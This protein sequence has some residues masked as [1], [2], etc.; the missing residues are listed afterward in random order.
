MQAVCQGQRPL[1]FRGLPYL[2]DCDVAVHCEDTSIALV[3]LR[4]PREIRR[5]VGPNDDRILAHLEQTSV[6]APSFHSARG[7]APSLGRP[8]HTRAPGTVTA[9]SYH[10]HQPRGYRPPPRRWTGHLRIR[11]AVCGIRLG[12]ASPG[13]GGRVAALLTYL[14]VSSDSTWSWGLPIDE[15]RSARG[16]GLRLDA[17]AVRHQTA[18]WSQGQPAVLGASETTSPRTSPRLRR[19]RRP[20][21]RGSPWPGPPRHRGCRP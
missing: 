5:P 7:L 6:L 18:G 8:P 1:R 21:A 13:N 16:V 3:R 17:A 11:A 20:G 4:R 12:S 19:L 15:M 14:S 2:H 9:Q 10:A